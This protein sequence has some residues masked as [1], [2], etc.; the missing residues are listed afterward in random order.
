MTEKS[1]PESRYLEIELC[2]NNSR[3]FTDNFLSSAHGSKWLI[4]G[5]TGFVGRWLTL[6]GQ[7]IASRTE[8]PDMVTVVT[9]DIQRA[10][11]ALR[12][13]L[14]SK[15]ELPEILP[16]DFLN[17]DIRSNSRIQKFDTIFH[18]ATPTSKHEKYMDDVLLVTS[19]L[20]E[21]CKRFNHPRFIHLSSGGVYARQEFQ[22]RRITEN[23]NRVA[24]TKASSVYQRT[25][26]MLEEKVER[27][28]EEGI[29]RGVNPRLFSFAGPGFPLNSHFA[30]AEFM[31]TALKDK[32]IVL[33]GNPDTCRSYMHPVTMVEWIL[34][35]WKYAD[36]IGLSPLHVGNPVSITM[37]ELATLV[38]D[39]IGGVTVRLLPN[40]H[41]IE[42][43][44]PEV[45]T[46]T[47]LGCRHD[48]YS[49]R[50]IIQSWKR[51][52]TE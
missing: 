18:A 22:G 24:A 33:R 37:M 15:Y 28:T 46:L 49:T 27:A 47:N 19:R 45:T 38:A 2:L 7:E 10:R 11:D 50:E 21:K 31:R 26:V 5:G 12:R 25:K 32:N 9:R 40:Q 36:Q 30:F 41:L 48:D 1:A 4:L 14:P 39:E 16:L 20:L 35:C 29:I 43:Y 23:V 17:S 8:K 6:F 34:T 42:W 52:G 13:F 44:V 51:Y 3:L